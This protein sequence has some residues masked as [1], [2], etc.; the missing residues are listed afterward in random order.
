METT[1]EKLWRAL[2]FVMAMLLTT[3]LPLSGAQAMFGKGQQSAA[4]GAPI[5]QAQE[6]RTY[7]GVACTGTLRAVDNEGESMTFALRDAPKKGTVELSEDGTFV[8]TPDDGR[9]GTDAFTFTATDASG[10]ASAPATVKI[11]I[12]KSASGVRYA[13]T[14]GCSAAAEAQDLAERGI[15]VGA[16]VG[17]RWFFEPDHAVTRGEFVA[18]CLKAADLKESEVTRTG[19]SDDAGIPAWAKSVAA[20]A[21]RSG[22]VRGVAT[23]GGAA[24]CAEKP[25]TLGEAASVLNRLLAVTDVDL[26][27]VLGESRSAWSAQAIAN[28]ESVSV[29]PSGSFG[30]PQAERV[31]TRAETAKLLSSAAEL[32]DSRA[33]KTGLLARLFG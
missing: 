10:N 4:P 24:F 9:A 17:E 15:F 5:A 19:F 27:D 3:L 1:R 23:D 18:M 22:V 20:S 6:C 16:R 12:L 32:I 33:E 11:R 30:G 25:I 28:L 14:D 8:Y 13:D 31:L 29:L 2:P 21:L 7:C 26:P